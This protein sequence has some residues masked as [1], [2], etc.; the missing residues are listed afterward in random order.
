MSQEFSSEGL[1]SS[2]KLG[3]TGVTSIDYK[4]I[5]CTRQGEEDRN[6]KCPE[7]KKIS[8]SLKDTLFVINQGQNNDKKNLNHEKKKVYQYKKVN[9]EFGACKKSKLQSQTKKAGAKG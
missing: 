2:R 5:N 9:Q 8:G 3:E 4:I 7:M 6:K 1:C